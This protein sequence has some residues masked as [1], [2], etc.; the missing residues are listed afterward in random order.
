VLIVNRRT[1]GDRAMVLQAAVGIG[2]A[3]TET[4]T[5]LENDAGAVPISLPAGGF[6][7]LAITR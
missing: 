5:A 7:L 4:G 6:R 2:L 1:D 3:D